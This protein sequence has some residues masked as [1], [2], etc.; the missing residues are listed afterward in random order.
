MTEPAFECK[1]ALLDDIALDLSLQG[2]AQNG[3]RLVA[4]VAKPGDHT[5][6]FWERPVNSPTEQM[7]S[8]EVVTEATGDVKV[9]IKE[10]STFPL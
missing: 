10:N 8:M 2:L 3:W 6:T 5:L 4:A 9:A 7:L 1:A